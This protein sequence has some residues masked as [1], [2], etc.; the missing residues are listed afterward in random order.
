MMSFHAL[1]I[2][3][4]EISTCPLRNA[5]VKPFRQ[6]EII[7]YLPHLASGIFIFRK[8]KL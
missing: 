8:I 1:A 3:G 6:V 7:N 5:S 2:S 4:S